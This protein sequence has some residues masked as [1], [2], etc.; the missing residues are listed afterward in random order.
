MTAIRCLHIN[1][2]NSKWESQ[3][4]QLIIMGNIF[5]EKM[6]F[7]SSNLGSVY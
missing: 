1:K 4:K 5:V 6:I 2:K 3:K 7:I